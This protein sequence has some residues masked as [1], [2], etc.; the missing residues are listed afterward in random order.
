MTRAH[1]VDP[2]GDATGEPE[3][4]FDGLRGEEGRRAAGHFRR[5]AMYSLVSGA[6]SPRMWYRTVSRWVM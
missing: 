6:V 2:P 3:D 5:W 4:L 1:V